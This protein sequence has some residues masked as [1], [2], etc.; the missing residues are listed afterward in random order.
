VLHLQA[1][2]FPLLIRLFH[3]LLLQTQHNLSI[4]KPKILEKSRI[5]R[6]RNVRLP[7]GKRF[8]YQRDVHDKDELNSAIEYY[9]QC[10]NNKDKY[11]R[12]RL[13]II[14]QIIQE[15]TFD[16]LRTKEQLGK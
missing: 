7:K 3:L 2:W 10:G 5:H 14:A 9:L 12:N 15:S 1:L 6:S 16:H 4:F 11:V 8:V 13:Q